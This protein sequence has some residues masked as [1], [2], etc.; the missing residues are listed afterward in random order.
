[1]CV[2]VRVRVIWCAGFAMDVRWR[3]DSAIHVQF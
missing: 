1:M 2:D 3:Y